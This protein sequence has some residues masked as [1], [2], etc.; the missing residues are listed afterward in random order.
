MEI[1][2]VLPFSKHK[3]IRQFYKFAIVGIVNTLVDLAVYVALT[4]SIDFFASHIVYANIIAFT[5]A[6][7]NSFYWNRRWTF[8][9][10][11]T[12]RSLQYI[13][14][15]IVNGAGLAIN[16]T[17]LY[18][19]VTYVGLYDIVAKSLAIG[20][21]LFWNFFISRIWTFKD[22]VVAKTPKKW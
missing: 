8:R 16:T 10:V 2:K 5:V 12:R 1:Q 3:S 13:K 17:I 6:V 15:F 7:S 4:R 19:L 14:F 9:S 22:S 21:A 20:V 11:D 18:C